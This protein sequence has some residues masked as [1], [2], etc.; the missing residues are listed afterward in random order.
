MAAV[1]T[2][3]QFA[4]DIANASTYTFSAQNFGT[5]AADRYIIAVIQSRKALAATTVSSVTIG[6]VAASISVQRAN[7][8]TN[9]SVCAIAIALVPTG[10]SGDVVVVFADAMTRCGLGLFSATGLSATPADTDSAAANDPSVSLDCPAG[11][12]IIAGAM[13]NLTGSA[14]WTGVT[15]R[16]D[17]TVE[18]TNNYT[19]GSL[20]FATTQTGLTVTATFTNDQESVGVFAS[21]GPAVAGAGNPWY[22]YQQQALAGGM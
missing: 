7:T 9:T 13:S 17:T 15:E 4:G 8:V 6:G 19:G 14:T 22:N 21:W 20:D 12:F 10:T 3:L 5:E 1:Q 18:A 11:G 2:F 16:W